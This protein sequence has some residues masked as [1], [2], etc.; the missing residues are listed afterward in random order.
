MPFDI[1]QVEKLQP[2]LIAARKLIGEEKIQLHKQTKN[3]VE[4][5]VAG[6]GV[7]HRV[8]IRSETDTVFKCT[9]PWHNKH[10]IQRGPCKH[11]L[12]A[13]IVLEE[14]QTDSK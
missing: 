13:Q 3:Q 12:A 9:C 11:I 14:S 2:R 7:E 1:S 8:V 6:S 10:G 4:F 5:G